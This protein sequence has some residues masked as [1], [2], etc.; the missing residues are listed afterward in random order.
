MLYRALGLPCFGVL[1]SLCL[2]FG[3]RT[4]RGR[5]KIVIAK[6]MES[7]AFPE[8]TYSSHSELPRRNDPEYDRQDNL[9][10]RKRKSPGAADN[11]QLER[12]QSELNERRD[13]VESKQ[14]IRISPGKFDVGFAH[15]IAARTSEEEQDKLT[16]QFFAWMAPIEF[17]E[18]SSNVTY[19]YPRYQLFL[20]ESYATNSERATDGIPPMTQC[21]VPWVFVKKSSIPKAGFGLFASR[22]FARG[23]TVGVYMGVTHSGRG[24]ASN[25]ENKHVLAGIDARG[26]I[27]SGYNYCLGAHF[28]N[29]PAFGGTGSSKKYKV[30]VHADGRITATRRVNRGQEFFMSYN[31]KIE[32]NNTCS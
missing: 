16:E 10:V 22:R 5:K 21:W 19:E 24:Q 13:V 2:K 30:A 15:C 4:D 7:S 11:N 26:G 32:P 28:I 25:V 29:E 6:H 18:G 20:N 3:V 17:K 27:G 31:N 8:D 12:T 23:E 14:L 9:K 1:F